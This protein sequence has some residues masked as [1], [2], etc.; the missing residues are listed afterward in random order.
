MFT[1]TWR[2]FRLFGVPISVDASWLIILVLLSWTLSGLFQESV[3]GLSAS[4][5]WIMGF[6]SA[7]A[8]FACVVLHELG[9]A[10]VA[11][12]LGIPIR[13]ITLFMLG[14][15]AELEDEPKSAASELLMAVA[16]PAVSL[17]LAAVFGVLSALIS[18]PAAAVPLQYLALI[19]VLVVL[20]NLL[21]AFPLDGGRVF[22]SILWL[23]M[24]N[25][26]RATFWASLSGQAFGWL[27]I[28]FCLFNLLVGQV[29]QAIWF[30]L[31]GL[32]LTNAARN[33]YQQVLLQQALRGEKVSRFM[34]QQPIAVPP[35]LDLQNWVEDYVYRHHRKFFPVTTNGHLE[36][37][38]TLQSLSK[39][40]RAEWSQ[41]TV[42]D[43][44]QTDVGELTISADADALKA[45][46]QMQRTG[47]SRLLVTDE[48]R[49]VGIISLKDLLRFL[50][51]KLELERID[52]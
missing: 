44:M 27:I 34:T 43:A 13:G 4:A 50:D 24:G 31:I 26:R 8:F 2:L 35:T 16:G 11:R 20:F 21:P 32:F 6:L 1:T 9:H 15:V 47:S 18:M 19:N 41:H 46:G 14:G 45:L 49:L 17:I 5:Y 25:L 33:S 52:E 23:T 40:P 30:G 10:L 51:L 36:G 37:A 12:A 38:I 39:F 42:A 3:V 22:R 29:A 28:S 7:L 48:E